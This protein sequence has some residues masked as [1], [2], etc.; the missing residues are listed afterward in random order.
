MGSGR[1]GGTD[2]HLG[3]GLLVILLF[4]PLHNALNQGVDDLPLLT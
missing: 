4:V 1:E 2:A 3:W